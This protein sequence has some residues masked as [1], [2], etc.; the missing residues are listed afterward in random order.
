MYIFVHEYLY[1]GLTYTK[2]MSQIEY[3]KAVG[4]EEDRC[5]YKLC[6]KNGKVNAGDLMAEVG[7]MG[8]RLHV[9]CY[10]KIRRSRR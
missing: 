1:I 8:Y 2:D 4:N 10:R 5:Q 6:P 3:G 7:I 9:S